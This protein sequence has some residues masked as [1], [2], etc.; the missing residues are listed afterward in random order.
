MAARVDRVGRSIFPFLVSLFAAMFFIGTLTNGVPYILGSG[1]FGVFFLTVA[2]VVLSAA[3]TYYVLRYS[4]NKLF[5]I[6]S[7]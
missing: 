5:S 3:L 6:W 7:N 4:I 2:A 1:V